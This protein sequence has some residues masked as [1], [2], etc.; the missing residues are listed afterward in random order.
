[1]LLSFSSFSTFPKVF[2]YPLSHIIMANSGNAPVGVVPESNSDVSSSFVG[3]KNPDLIDIFYEVDPPI[4]AKN[5]P[6]TVLD[7]VWA[8]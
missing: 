7:Q 4:H 5:M 3:V 2:L 6:L 8:P 1:M